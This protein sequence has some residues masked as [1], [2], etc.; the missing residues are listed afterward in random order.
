METRGG[1]KPP[2][3]KALS[4]EELDAI[5]MAQA[6]HEKRLRVESAALDK[7]R[8]WLNR[9][10]REFER[11]KNTKSTIASD[12]RG[13]LSALKNEMMHE[14]NMLRQYVGN[15]RSATRSLTPPA[16]QRMHS[17]TPSPTRRRGSPYRSGAPK[18]SFREIL[19][20]VP[21]FDRYHV[22]LTQ[23]ARARRRA[24]EIAPANHEKH[25]T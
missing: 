3:K 10:K 13:L 1:A 16:G 2:S 25:L 5:R 4:E 12:M 7:E 19:E 17:A 15:C 18:L 14:I 22:L 9:K 11:N 21:R 20:D 24:R 23:F 8:N 6:Q